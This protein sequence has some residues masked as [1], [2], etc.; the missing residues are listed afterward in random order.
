M[1]Q[2]L[3]DED[4]DTPPSVRSLSPSTTPSHHVTSSTN[5]NRYNSNSRS[6]GSTTSTGS[7]N[8][9]LPPLRINIPDA[10][11]FGSPFPSPT[12]TISAANSCP[13]SPRGSHGRRNVSADLHMVAAYAAQVVNSNFV[14][15][16]GSSQIVSQESS[17]IS[18]DNSSIHSQ[19]PTSEYRHQTANGNSV[20]LIY[21]T[22]KGF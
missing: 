8:H 18:R 3:V 22:L 14:G 11:S 2:S 7:S 5:H 9:P 19:S 17:T 15:S 20:S 12:G 6:R 4:A 1:F 16:S 13:T 10:D 21:Q